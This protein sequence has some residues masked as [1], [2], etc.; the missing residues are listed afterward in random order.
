MCSDFHRAESG[1]ELLAR[2]EG[3]SSLKEIEPYLFADEESPVHGLKSP[4]MRVRKADGLC[5]FAYEIP[6]A[7]DD[8]EWCPHL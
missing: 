7:T 2:L 1:T 5:F 4:G 8:A 3:R 6:T